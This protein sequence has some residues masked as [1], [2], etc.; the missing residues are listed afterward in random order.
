VVYLGLVALLDN[1][2]TAQRGRAATAEAAVVMSI[3]TD[4]DEPTDW[5]D[6]FE[7]TRQQEAD[8]KARF[9]DPGDPLTFLIVARDAASAAPRL[10]TTEYGCRWWWSSWSG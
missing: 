10:P 1:Q 8:V 2:D 9:R 5:R 4:K 7:L 3:G 6:R